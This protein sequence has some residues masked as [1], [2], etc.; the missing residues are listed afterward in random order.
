M[1]D[2]QRLAEEAGVALDLAREYHDLFVQHGIP[3]GKAAAARRGRTRRLIM[4]STHGYWGDPPPA[5]VP[6]TGGQV[7]YVLKV[8]KAWARQG[9]QVLILVRWFEDSPRVE[10]FADGVWL[11]RLRAGGNEFV[12]KEDIYGLTPQLGEAGTAVGALFGAEG[13]MGHYAD[14]MAVAVEMGER[15]ELPV[16]CVPHSMGVLKMLR[17]SWDPL[18]QAQLRDPE[19]HFWIRE[20]FE[21]A[22]LRG[23]NFE[24]ANTPREPEILAQ[25]Y[26]LRFPHQVM[27][28]GAARAFSE[29]GKRPPDPAAPARFGLIEKRYVLFWGR[30][31]EAKFVEGVV[32]VLGEARRLRPDLAGDLKAVIVGGSPSDPSEEERGIEKNIRAE[33]R[34]YGL[35]SS[36]VI[37]V[38][39]QTHARMARLARAGLAYVGMQLLEPFGMVAAEA[40]AA[41]LPVLISSAAGITRWLEDG[42]HALFVHPDDPRAAAAKLLRLIEDP[43]YWER[44][45][46]EGRKKA[47][48]DFSWDGI[49]RK[50]GAVMDRLCAG[51]DPR[52]AGA[53]PSADPDH[54]AR[55][56]GRAFHRSTPAWRG[57]IPHIKPHHISASCELVPRLVPRIRDSAQRGER[58]TVALAGESG[59]GKS[60][61]AHLLTLMLRKEGI[62]GTVIPGD[63]F[64]ILPPARNHANRLA[65]YQRGRLDE[66]VGPREVDLERLDGVLAKARRRASS[67]VRI[68]ADCRSIPGRR[69]EDVPVALDGVDALFIDLTY[70]LLLDNAT[71][72]VFLERSALDDID[73]VR[74]R[75]LARDPDQDFGF[76][77]RV[78]ELEHQIIGP[79]VERADIVVDKQY[80]VRG[81]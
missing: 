67:V 30:L 21:L 68:P 24:I 42:K 9:R 49:A 44:L 48:A 80:Q 50:Q 55:R 57:D 70:S 45:S 75:N 23:A 31:S 52:G 64:F 71:F 58:L 76:I 61:I 14:G 34:R 35:G 33:M 59:S 69:Y 41:G 12:R 26:G 28:A 60:E 56:S 25:H 73:A 72:K 38:E 16:V 32:Q 53:E 19:Y 66:A 3:M 7:Y 65:A 11:V 62:L 51:K 43:G 54:F 27:P 6:D 36:D 8:A 20:S 39:S 18:D 78:L 5:G 81:S 74:E 2:L 22:A 4:V 63:A 40:M 47:L 29:V 77:E 15:L 37:R 13:V 17:L 79:L 10:R 1:A 46:R